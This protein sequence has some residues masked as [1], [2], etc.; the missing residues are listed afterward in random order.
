MKEEYRLKEKI[1]QV[2]L[3][4]WAFALVGPFEFPYGILKRH[5]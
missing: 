5:E 1:S 3:R 4:I 2:S